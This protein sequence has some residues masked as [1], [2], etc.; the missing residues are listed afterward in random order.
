MLHSDAMTVRDDSGQPRLHRVIQ[1]QPALVN[2][3][4]ND[5]G[6]ER[7]RSSPR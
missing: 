5:R 3:L 6:D 7:L 2:Q 1:P 4:Q